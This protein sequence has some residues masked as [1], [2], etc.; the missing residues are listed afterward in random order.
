MREKFPD[1]YIAGKNILKSAII[2]GENAGGKSN[3]IKSLSYLQSLFKKTQPIES[4]LKNIYDCYNFDNKTKIIDTT[5]R[6]F[7]AALIDD[8]EYHYKL[9]FDYLG[10]KAEIF[11]QVPLNQTQENKTF[12]MERNEENISLTFNKIKL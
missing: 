7:I 2:V 3:F 9:E 12:I 11:S 4:S 10:I 6:F 1:N 8:C 5:Q